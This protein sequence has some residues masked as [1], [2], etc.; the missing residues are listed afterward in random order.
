MKRKKYIPLAITMLL[1]VPAFLTSCQEDAPEINYT[2]SVSVIND[3]TKVVEAIDRG[4]L[5]NEEAIAK[6]ADAIDRM[7]SDQQ[8]KLQAIR[9]ILGSVNTAL[10]T[11]LVALEAAL[12]AQT[13]SLVDKLDLLEAAVNALPDYGSQ[14]AAISTAIANLPATSCRGESGLRDV[15][16]G[17]YW[18]SSLSTAYSYNARYLDFG[19]GRHDRNVNPLLL[20]VLG[21]ARPP[22]NLSCPRGHD[23]IESI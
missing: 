22:I 15:G 4:A 11:R 17:Y 13:L 5:K 9:D 18:S 1:A 6:L 23:A 16:R 12:K 10:E 21:A 20:R 2:M 19:S 3:F 14:L 7:I 8:A